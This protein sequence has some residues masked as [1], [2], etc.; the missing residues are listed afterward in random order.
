MP[1]FPIPKVFC[2]DESY[3]TGSGNISHRPEWPMWHAKGH[4]WGMGMTAIFG[5]KFN[6]LNI[7]DR[8]I[9]G[10]QR[11]IPDIPDS[12]FPLLSWVFPGPPYR[13]AASRKV[14]KHCLWHFFLLKFLDVIVDLLGDIICP[15]SKSTCWFH[16]TWASLLIFGGDVLQNCTAKLHCKTALQ[17]CTAAPTSCRQILSW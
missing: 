6:V 16:D 14:E 1:D 8:F 11:P 5:N 12:E 9:F 2:L 17:N 15:I 4:G 7:V 10:I 13:L 3:Y